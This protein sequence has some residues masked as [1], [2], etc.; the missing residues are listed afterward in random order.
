MTPIAA[1]FTAPSI[2]YSAL[3]PIL[4]VAGAAVVGVLVEAFA[5][6]LARWPAQVAVSLAGLVA[7]FVAVCLLAH[8]HEITAAGAIAVDGPALFMQGTIA[9]IGIAS[10]LLVADRSP[11]AGGGSLVAQAA[12]LPGSLQAMGG[13]L[14]AGLRGSQGRRHV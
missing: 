5:P 13:G 9:L 1:D 10:V 6:R 3:A 7:S 11:G 8:T 14:L 4:I 2:S 12:T